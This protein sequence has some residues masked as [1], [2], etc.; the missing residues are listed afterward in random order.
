MDETEIPF[1]KPK[2]KPMTNPSLVTR[3]YRK[4]LEL[5]RSIISYRHFAGQPIAQFLHLL[6]QLQP[7]NKMKRLLINELKI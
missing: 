5:G 2:W 6:V 7:N 4:E 3:C 1:L